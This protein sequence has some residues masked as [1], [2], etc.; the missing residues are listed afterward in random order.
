MG[1]EIVNIVAYNGIQI[2]ETTHTS[3]PS[4]YVECVLC[5]QTPRVEGLVYRCPNCRERFGAHPMR[6][7]TEFQ[8]G[9]RAELAGPEFKRWVCEWLRVPDDVLDI[10]LT[11]SRII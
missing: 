7:G 10:K 4:I 5:R 6:H 8:F 1:I 11:S 9:S 3:A 2:F